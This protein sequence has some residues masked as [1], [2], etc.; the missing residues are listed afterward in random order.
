MI[1]GKNFNMVVTPPRPI[2]GNELESIKRKI[3]SDNAA[4]F[5]HV[6]K[7]GGTSITQW[8]SNDGNYRT[9]M[10]KI[11]NKSSRH[12]HDTIY[13]EMDEIRS[14]NPIVFTVVR[15]PYDWLASMNRHSFESDGWRDINKCLG[16]PDSYEL[17]LERFFNHGFDYIEHNDD[18]NNWC[19]KSLTSSGKK[20]G[21]DLNCTKH[22]YWCFREFS[23]WQTFDTLNDRGVKMNFADVYIRYEKLSEGLELLFGDVAKS[24]PWKNKS[25][26]KS[27]GY[28]HM[29]NTTS[30]N[31]VECFRENELKLF[32]YDFDG[33]I[34][35]H[36][37]IVPTSAYTF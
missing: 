13:L 28:K 8:K 11:I 22:D 10:P 29:Y 15:N 30:K 14:K 37:L 26:G 23:A 16:N 1:V 34:D 6:P 2:I 12:M 5:I 19:W 21:I 7:T 27:K 9:D 3:R 35:D 24:L 4:I 31:I 33:P 36:P 18:W 20:K 25:P 32:G 17:F